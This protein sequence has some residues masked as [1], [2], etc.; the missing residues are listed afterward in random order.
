MVRRL[1]E[2]VAYH[3]LQ[4]DAARKT[5]PAIFMK[6]IPQAQ[7]TSGRVCGHLPIFLSNNRRRLENAM[8]RC[9]FKIV[10]REN[11]NTFPAIQPFRPATFLKK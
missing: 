5:L 8:T 9:N 10:I 4:A 6:E 7:T 1:G 11:Y 2:F 3:S